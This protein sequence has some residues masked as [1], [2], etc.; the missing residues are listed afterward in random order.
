MSDDDK[1]TGHLVLTRRL[2][3]SVVVHNA[4][5]AVEVIV[6]RISR[7]S[8]QL[9]FTDLYGAGRIAVH[10]AELWEKLEDRRDGV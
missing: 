4:E 8:V 9:R 6:H 7:D 5:V 1:E 10:R 3:Q 2:G